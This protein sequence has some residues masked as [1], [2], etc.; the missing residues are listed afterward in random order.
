[1]G[2]FVTSARTGRGVFH[3]RER[4]HNG[5]RAATAAPSRRLFGAPA[6]RYGSRRP[7]CRVGFTLAELLVVIGLIALLIAILLPALSRAREAANQVKCMSNLRQLTIAFLMYANDNRGSFPGAAD[8]DWGFIRTPR[9]TDWIYW[10]AGR[11]VNESAVA[12]YLA[13]RGDALRAVLRCPSDD[14]PPRQVPSGYPDPYNYS[15]QMNYLLDGNPFEMPMPLYVPPRLQQVRHPSDKIVLGETYT[16]FLDYG[17]WNIGSIAG[18]GAASNW[19]PVV[20][21]S[22][23][24]DQPSGLTDPVNNDTWHPLNPGRRGNVS[25]CDGHAEF[26]PRSFVAMREHADPRY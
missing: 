3:P 20:P 12:P 4:R 10:Q 1:M 5:G 25:F 26:V 13:A 18:T 6:V 9:P 17:S 21:I 14:P 16:R 22:I 11:D 24:H 7:D 2:F 23:R 19:R 15:Y 8:G